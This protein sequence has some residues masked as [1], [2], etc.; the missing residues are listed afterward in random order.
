MEA[1]DALQHRQQEIQKH[2]VVFNQH[3]VQGAHS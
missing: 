1:R 3:A 2:G